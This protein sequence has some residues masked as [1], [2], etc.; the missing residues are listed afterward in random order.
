M[1][2][3][4]GAVFLG[5]GGLGGDELVADGGDLRVDGRDGGPVGADGLRMSA[6]AVEG[7]GV[8]PDGRVGRAVRM[9]RAVRLVEL[10]GARVRFRAPGVQGGPAD[11]QAGL[12]GVGAGKT[13]GVQP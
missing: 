4:L 2:V 5:Q 9:Q 7:E 12:V 13:D 10:R 8:V 6:V 3:G 11:P 1:P